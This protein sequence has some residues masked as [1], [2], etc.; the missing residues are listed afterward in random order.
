MSH[1][2]CSF[3]EKIE[4]DGTNYITENNGLILKARQNYTIVSNKDKYKIEIVRDDD[5]EKKVEVAVTQVLP[6]VSP[7]P[8]KPFKLPYSS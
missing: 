8:T 7:I 3:S 6:K 1:C 2:S 4:A 5:N